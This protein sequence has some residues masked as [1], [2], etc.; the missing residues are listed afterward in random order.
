MSLSSLLAIARTAL[1]ARQLELDVA[2]HNIANAR[3]EG[4]TRQRPR[5]LPNTPLRLPGLGTLGTGVKIDGIDQARSR[6]LDAAYRSERAAQGRYQ[7]REQGLA[8]IEAIFGEPSESGLA[9]KLD[10][11]WNAWHDLANS[12]SDSAARWMVRTRGEQLAQGFNGLDRQLA[13]LAQDTAAEADQLVAQ[14]N[15]ALERLARLNA[16]I[17]AAEAGHRTAP[18]LRDERGRLLDQLASWLPVRALE[19]SDGTVALLADEVLLVDGAMARQIRLTA[20]PGGRFQLSDQLSGTPLGLSGG[21]LAGLLDLAGTTIPA[22]R[23]R[24]DQLASVLV[25]QINTL[26][27]SGVTPAGDRD[28][29]FFDPVGLSAQTIRL[30][31]PI[32]QSADRI[33]AGSSGAPGDGTLA[34]T[35]ASLRDTALG[36]LGGRRLGQFYTDLVAQ[37]AAATAEARQSAESQD[38]LVAQ[39]ANQ[40]SSISDVSLDEELVSLI[41]SQQ[42]YAAAARLIGVA[43]EMMRELLRAVGS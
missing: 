31:A 12:P 42:G 29:D 19:R 38:T 25:R 43:D 11:F 16:Q 33:A 3:T 2:G 13:Q 37:V 30:A 9:A 41:T 24:L 27:R 17:A 26:H 15:G 39:L 34:Q 28:Q 35:V 8:Q 20:Q 18:D 7:A 1:E 40:R 5:V 4:Y 36:E 14:V 21:R 22:L 10:A 32:Q 23:A 6:L